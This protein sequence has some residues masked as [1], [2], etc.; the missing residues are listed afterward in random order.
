MDKT[1]K[2]KKIK[3][4]LRRLRKTTHSIDV[5]MQLKERYERRLEYLKEGKDNKNKKEAAKILKNISALRVEKY[6]KEATELESIYMNAIS[7]LEPIDKVIIIDGY[8]NGKAYW[9]IGHE[10][11]YTEAGVQKRA[12]RIIEK[13]AEIV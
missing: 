3:A 4:D 13:L 7:K 10:I 2:V 12:T 11:G 5:M 9:K 8:I 1:K 6:I